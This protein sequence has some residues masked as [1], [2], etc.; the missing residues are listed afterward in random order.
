MVDVLFFLIS[1]TSIGI[2]AVSNPVYAV[3]ILI[4]IFLQ[5]TVLFFLLGVEFFSIL[6][7]TVYIGAIA[8]LFLFVVMLLDLRAVGGFDSKYYNPYK[9]WFLLNSMGL[10]S[11]FLVYILCAPKISFDISDYQEAPTLIITQSLFYK[12]NIHTL[13]EL[14]YNYYIIYFFIIGLILLITIFGIVILIAELSKFS[15]NTVV[16]DL[17][18]LLY[19]DRLTTDIFVEGRYPLANFTSSCINETDHISWKNMQILTNSLQINR[20][21]SSYEVIKKK[22]SLLGWYPIIEK[23]QQSILPWNRYLEKSLAEGDTELLEWVFDSKVDILE[24][25]IKNGDNK[26]Q[27]MQKN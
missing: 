11:L 22:P 20:S 25:R 27:V 19:E 2:T 21:L 5:T 14:M 18:S 26:G 17:P 8:V 12:T 6:L 4:I 13:S 15:I 24:E 9:N 16:K 3:F 1:L 23:P 7:I 10:F